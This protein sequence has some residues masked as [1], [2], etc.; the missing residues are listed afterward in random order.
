MSELYNPEIPSDLKEHVMRD[1]QQAFTL[2]LN[3]VV[4][5]TASMYTV[6]PAVYYAASHLLE[7]L[8]RYEVYPE[9]G[10]TILRNDL[11][12]Q[13]S[14]VVRFQDGS[15]YTTDIPAFLK[16]LNSVNLY[17]GGNDGRESVHTA[18]GKAIRTFP[19][20]GRNRALLIFT[21]AY[22]SNDY[23]DYTGDPLGQVVFFATQDLSEEDF[24]F[25]LVRPDGE[26]DEEASPMF[27]SITKLLKPMSTEL[28]SNIA[29]PLKDLM[30]GVSI[31]A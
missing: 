7:A 5:G 22:G 24:R 10:L 11:E 26:M 21:D 28:I 23:E 27:I 12:G 9:L 2:Y 15:A 13:E 1:K 18:I 14:E 6:F 20:S 17:G 29:K 16:K 31:G 4:D 25:C 30:K 19:V 3:F 8:S